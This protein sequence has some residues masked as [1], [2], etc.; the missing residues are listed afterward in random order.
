MAP[1]IELAA[2]DSFTPGSSIICRSVIGPFPFAIKWYEYDAA[3]PA[4]AWT[5]CMYAYAAGVDV[6]VVVI[7]GVTVC[8]TV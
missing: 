4:T 3:S 2:P 1:V 8:V 5:G 6:D 7:V